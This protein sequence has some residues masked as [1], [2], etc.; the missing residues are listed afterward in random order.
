MTAKHIV[1]ACVA[2]L[3]CVIGCHAPTSPSRPNIILITLDTTRADRLSCYGYSR[4]TSPNLDQF[5]QHAVRYTRAV[6]PATWTLPSH[7]SLF[8]GKFVSSHGAQYDANGPLILAS[9]LHGPTLDQ[10][11][12]RGLAAGEHTLAMI[13]KQAGYTTAAVVGGV[14]LK[15]VFGLDRGFDVYDDDDISSENGRPAAQITARAL[16]WL[17]AR[18]RGPFLLFLNYFDP[19]KPY[20]PPEGYAEAFLPKGSLT[21]GKRLS[22]D[23][24]NALYDAEI[25]YMDH[26]LGELFAGLKQMGL[27][28]NTWIIIT[29]DHGELL[30]EHG[31][32]LHGD[33]PYQEIIHVPLIVKDPGNGTA[34]GPTDV[35]VEL[36]DILP[37]ILQRLQLPLPADIQGSVP[38]NITHPI[39]AESHPLPVFSERGDWRTILNGD[40]KF[41]WNSK[42]SN[43]LFNLHDDPHEAVNLL[44]QQAD[45]A[46]DMERAMTQYLL[47]LP[48]PGASEPVREVDEKTR[49]ALRRLGYL[50]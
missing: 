42:G 31:E 28:D 30:G 15:R 21:P 37:M 6:A 20:S 11:R 32:F 35:R 18:P 27:F 7:A 50:H 16:R 25:L 22:L 3:L 38:P 12:A 34:P 4:P 36:T 49:E 24:V 19:H 48:R 2:S 14:W 10:Y 43:F 39:L 41:I 17:A 1:R 26:Y 8:T 9:V 23:E 45:T 40:L 33:S 44:G 47:G 29:A 46:A 13:V 5:A